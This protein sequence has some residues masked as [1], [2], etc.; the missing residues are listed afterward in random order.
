MFFSSPGDVS[1]FCF[2]GLF[3]EPMCF[4]VYCLH[5]FFQPMKYDVLLLLSLCDISYFVINLLA[6][7]RARRIFYFPSHLSHYGG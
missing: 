6:F 7:D 1:L 3:F 4:A 5:S 2:S